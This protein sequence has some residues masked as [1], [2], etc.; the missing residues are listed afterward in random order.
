MIFNNIHIFSG[1]YSFD[2]SDHSSYTFIVKSEVLAGE[3]GGSLFTGKH[4]CLVLFLVLITTAII[5]SGILKLDWTNW[6]DNLLVYENPRVSGARF[7]DIFTKPAEYNT[8]NP[9]V[10]SSFALEWALVK[11]RPFLYHFDNLILHL[12]CTALVWFFFRKLGLSVWWSGFGALL[13]GIHPMRVESVAWIAE[14]KDGLFG[15]FYLAALLAYI[16]YIADEK[17]GQ[18]ALTF[19]FF[20]LA[21]LSKGQA[22][23][24]P[25]TL[26]LLDW[27]FQRK[28]TLKVV[29]EKV[30]FFAMAL[31]TA[32]LTITFFVK[33]VYAAADKKTI[34]YVFNRFEQMILGGYAYTVYIL[35]SIIPYEISPL[36]PMPA[37]L[38]PEHWIGG[39]TAVCIF[40]I[41]LVSWR[42]RRFITFGLL[43]FTFNIFFLLMPFLMNETAFLFDHY[44]Y[45]AYA[46]LFFVMAMSI[47]QLSERTPSSRTPMVLLA[48]ALLMVFGVMTIKYI[49]VWTNS[50]TLWTYVIEKYP[51]NITIAYL[52]RGHYWYKNHQSGK[53]LED[54]STAIEINPTFPRAYMNRSLI[55]L[56]A[57]DMEKALRDYNR[58][59]DLLPPFDTGGDVLNPPMSDVLSNRGVIYSQ[60]GS[61][62]KALMDFNLAVKLN[63]LNV[64][65]YVKRA[66]VYMQL[67]EYGNAIRDFNLSHRYDPTNPD[68]LNNRG[69]CYL[70]SGDFNSA[71]DDFSKAILLNGS[72]PLYYANR[73]GAYH[74][75]GRPKEARQD[76][77][78][79]E[80]MGSIME[81]SFAK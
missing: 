57:N 17:N 20:I 29:L 47:Q 38:R 48:A 75:L 42:K 14:R 55:Y 23:A 45:V 77:L 60:A 16:R 7:K 62:E 65:N 54:V 52:N 39:A 72:N 5:F 41:A 34:I 26:I 46:G 44:T 67:H 33:N 21:L 25:F 71:L 12:L 79:A 68:I 49:P 31:M 40:V 30:I 63:P 66:F 3:K 74:K 58:Y 50:E 24:L 76:M 2:T 69:V 37:F 73:A 61:Y 8:F 80:K 59:M 70:R 10:I 19:L 27:Y 56:E 11:D 36:Y 81:P 51:R 22:V 1:K 15:L 28:V 32:L 18:L 78:T 53:A 13:F 9:L 4:S 6:D 64:S 43:F 35:K